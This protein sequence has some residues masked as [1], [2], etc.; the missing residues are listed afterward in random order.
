MTEQEYIKHNFIEDEKHISPYQTPYKFS[1]KEKDEESGYSYFGAR[2]YDADLSV[3]LSVDPM[4]GEFPYLSPYAFCA[5]NP[6][7]YIDPDGQRFIDA[8]GNRVRVKAG[9]DGSISYRFA[10]GTSAETQSTFKNNHDPSLTAMATTKDGRKNVRFMNSTI[11]NI[12]IIPDNTVAP[13]NSLVIPETD[14]NGQPKMIGDVY[15]K[16]TI[17][18]H[19]GTIE[20]K[21]QSDGVD[22]S[23]ILGATMMVESGH[24]K[25]KQ[26]ALDNNG[27]KSPEQKYSK[28]FNDYVGFR[29]DYRK[30]KNQQLN[31]T[32]F[33]NNSQIKPDL[34]NKNSNRLKEVSP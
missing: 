21:A 30:A 19:M 13:Q 11:T 4:A 24:L 33:N 15:D 5:N 12:E 34:N 18:P 1:G 20:A 7:R 8:N 22:V 2:Y 14:A 32:I 23:E 25:A 9:R 31:T 29:Y 17:T 10:K 6:I 16:V 26:I 3:W 28:L 27:N